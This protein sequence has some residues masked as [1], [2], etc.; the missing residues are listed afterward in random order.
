[1]SSDVL[2]GHVAVPDALADDDH[3]AVCA[4]ALAASM[5]AHAHSVASLYA[6]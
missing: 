5:R 3:V 2:I 6:L 1:M 4:L